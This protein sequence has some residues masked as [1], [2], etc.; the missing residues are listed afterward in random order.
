MLGLDM[1]DAPGG[2][3]RVADPPVSSQADH[4]IAQRIE[5]LALILEQG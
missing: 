5:D 1:A 2:C 4:G 3:V